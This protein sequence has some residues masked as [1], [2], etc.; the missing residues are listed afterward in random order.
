MR[1]QLLYVMIFLMFVSCKKDSKK[2]ELIDNE[3]KIFQNIESPVS[4]NSSLPSLFSNG[5]QLYMSWVEK[6]DSINRLKYSMYSQNKW[7]KTIEISSGND[8]FINW[9]D[10]P[11]I[12]ENNG[13]IASSLLQKSDS[14]TYTYDI[15]L[16]LYS[17]V[18]E[19]WKNNFLLN[20]DGTKSEHGFVS[21]LPFKRNS[22]FVTWLDGR[23][24]VHVPKGAEQMTLRAAIITEDGAIENDTLLDERTCDCCN[25]SAAL[26]PNGPVVVYRDRSS[27]DIRDISIVRFE[28]GT[29][30]KPQTVIEDNWYIPGCPVNGPEIDS[31]DE[32]LVLAWF[33]SADDNPKVQ[34]VFSEDM[35]KSFGLPFRID[36]G[37]AIGR[38]DVVMIDANSAAVL[39]MEPS[40][41][42][43]IIRLVKINS[44]GTQ[45]EPITLTKT[46]SERSSGFPQLERVGDTLFVAW[47]SL[48]NEKPK[49]EVL[50]IDLKKI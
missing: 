28:N 5:K 15:K 50:S 11:V 13:M 3:A 37:N 31:F 33:T 8:W 30:S 14:G 48:E 6:Q 1:I 21:M 26:T 12:A 22:F 23:T 18:N 4:T 47:T 41:V 46:R 7:G 24:T 44:D 49:I 27:E 34:V 43:T 42:D 17:A 40:G 45:N 35:G 36:N 39:W 2:N 9:A 32:S 16:N 25:T 20:R 19:K 10:Y 29:W 38:V